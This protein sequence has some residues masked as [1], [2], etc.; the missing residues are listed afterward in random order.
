MAFATLRG[1]KL[2]SFLTI[3]GVVVG[4]ITVMIISSIILAS[5]TF[6]L[7]A[8]AYQMKQLP[9]S[10][11]VMATGLAGGVAAIFVIR[12]FLPSTPYFNR[13]LLKPPEG[14]ELEELNRRESLVSWGHLAGKT[15]FT[16]T[17]LIPAGK[18]QFGDELVD[19][20]SDGEMLDRGTN[21]YV[22][23]VLGNRVV[24][25]RAPGH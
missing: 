24:V 7:P 8:N 13:M 15:G 5:Q 4:V 25:K 2:R 14:E 21:V 19:V 3:I 23:E 9:V 11:L 17:P 10:L 1:N 12:R 22:A 18:A 6:V 16:T 20:I